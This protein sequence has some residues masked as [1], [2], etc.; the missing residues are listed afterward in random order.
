MATS[1]SLISMGAPEVG[2]MLGMVSLGA[3]TLEHK[4][5]E[6]IETIATIAIAMR[7]LW[8]L[9]AMLDIP[10]AFGSRLLPEQP[11]EITSEC[12]VEVER[13]ANDVRHRRDCEGDAQVMGCADE[14][15][16]RH[17]AARLAHGFPS[18]FQTTQGGG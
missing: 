2:I 6:T 1:P 3:L 13:A 10:A 9:A 18:N 5:I 14:A 17:Y 8:Y 16:S 12:G 7:S 11:F 15:K 4:T